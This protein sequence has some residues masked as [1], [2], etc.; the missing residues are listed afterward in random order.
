MSKNYKYAVGDFVTYRRVGI[1]K[2]TDIVLQNFVRQGNSEYYELNSVYDTNTKVFVPVDSKLEDEMKPMLDSSEI[3]KIIKDSKLVEDLWVEDCKERAR[4]FEGIV[5]DGDKAKM[6]W[7]IKR[8][9][10]H[11]AEMEEARKKVKATDTRYLAL[12]ESIIA[13]DFA[14]SLGLAK[15]Q[16]MDYINDY[17][18][19]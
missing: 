12:C 4:V 19:K 6:L 18:N 10:E 14:Y 1:C 16:V 15:N 17:L 13:G 3:D 2:I 8:V 5:N 9:S 7:L 11:K